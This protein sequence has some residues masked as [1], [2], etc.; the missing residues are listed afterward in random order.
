MPSVFGRGWGTCCSCMW[1][2]IHHVLA[3]LQLL[4]VLCNPCSLQ[5]QPRLPSHL[6]PF[7]RTPLLRCDT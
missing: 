1:M 4:A 7:Q 2:V 6:T 3:C 5:Q